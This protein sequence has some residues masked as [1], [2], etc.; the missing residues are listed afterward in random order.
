MPQPEDA[1]AC[2]D[3]CC[4]GPADPRIARHFDRRAR[5]S[6]AKGALP[7]LHDVSAHLLEALGAPEGNPSLLELGCG[8][9]AL[10]VDLLTHGARS[11]DGIDLSPGSIETARRRAEKAGVADRAHFAVADGARTPLEPHDWVVLDRVLCCYRDVDA[12]LESAATAAHRRVAFSIPVSWGW[13]GAIRR[14]MLRLEALSAPARGNPCPGFVHDVARIEE[15]LT[16]LGFRPTR[17]ARAGSWYVA[18]FDRA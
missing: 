6:T 18:V 8:S 15:R 7:P 4:A 10:T 14:L 9:G 5:E 2:T 1:T 3:S 17:R 11:A 13:R 16:A 12:L